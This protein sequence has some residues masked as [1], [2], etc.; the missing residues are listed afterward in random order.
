MAKFKHEK[1][2]IDDEFAD[3]A[4]RFKGFL[5]PQLQARRETDKAAGDKPWPLHKTFLIVGGTSVVLWLVIVE[6]L[7][8]VL[9]L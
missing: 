9:G 4:D 1:L 7:H 8:F 3:I 2:A 5:D 6:V